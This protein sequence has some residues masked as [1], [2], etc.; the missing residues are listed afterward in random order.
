MAPPELELLVLPD[1]KVTPEPLALRGQR[2]PKESRVWLALLAL[3][4]RKVHK[5]LLVQLAQPVPEKL[6]QQEHKE[7]KV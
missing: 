1:R 2:A 5:V 6:V 7:P 3:L 4:G